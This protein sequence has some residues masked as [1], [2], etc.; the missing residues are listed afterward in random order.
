M[1]FVNKILCALFIIITISQMNS[2]LVEAGNTTIN[3]SQQISYADESR[4]SFQ[5]DETEITSQA[6]ETE[7]IVPTS[8][9]LPTNEQW[10]EL[11]LEEKA[12]TIVSTIYLNANTEN[13]ITEE[14]IQVLL[15]EPDEVFEMNDQIKQHL[16]TLEDGGR[17]IALKLT[18]DLEK[19]DLL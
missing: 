5:S 13:S 11:S 4:L 12:H 9:T 10:A 15:G 1:K 2:L 14:Q 19:K 6:H 7:F 8:T 3:A 17:K 18:Y 16:F